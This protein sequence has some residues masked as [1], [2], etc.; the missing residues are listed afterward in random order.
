MSYIFRIV[1][2]FVGIIRETLTQ[3]VAARLPSGEISLPGILVREI[4]DGR[5]SATV[6]IESSSPDAA[7]ASGVLR[8]ESL[9]KLLAISND[10][11]EIEFSV[12]TA[13]ILRETNPTES[14][15]TRD[16]DRINITVGDTIFLSEHLGLVKTRAN[17]EFESKALV[18]IGKWPDHLRRGIDL[19][20]SAVRAA[21]D[22][23]KFLLLA[24]ALEILAWKKLGAPKTLLKSN[25]SKGTISRIYPDGLAEGRPILEACL[26]PLRRALRL[27]S[28]SE[29]ASYDAFKAKFEQFL[30][31]W[32]F[33]NAEVSRLRDHLLTTNKEPV[34]HHLVSYLESTAIS[35]F[36]V[37]EV[38]KWWR[39]R[40]KIAHGESIRAEELQ[41]VISRITQAVQSALKEELAHL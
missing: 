39:M 9:L 16:G 20:Y 36:A 40:G 31:P 17:L 32:G 11:F 12:V 27:L 41:Q 8:V 25:L 30:K 22:N 33:T 15:I 19:N 35:G 28:K 37:P 1:V 29:P 3:S 21:T 23:I 6:E 14:T 13:E 34:A 5:Y 4:G 2:S 38:A 7:K 18:D 26:A 10:L 24:S